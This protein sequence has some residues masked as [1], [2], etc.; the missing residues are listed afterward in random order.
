MKISLEIKKVCT[1]FCM[2]E[3]NE[4][5]VCCNQVFFPF[6][7]SNVYV[8]HITE[9]VFVNSVTVSKVFSN[10]VPVMAFFPR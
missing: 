9:F 10:N 5:R 6:S 3:D 1:Q 4:G 8:R 2:A 7:N